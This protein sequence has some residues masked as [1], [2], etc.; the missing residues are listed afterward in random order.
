VERCLSACF[1]AVVVA[2]ATAAAA[3]AAA[4]VDDFVVEG[5]SQFP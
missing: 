4:G 5:S 3:A 1:L 2:A